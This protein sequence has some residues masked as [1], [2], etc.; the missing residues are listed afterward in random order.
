[1]N[2]QNLS[3][4][5]ENMA[6]ISLRQLIYDN[7]QK[8]G[9]TILGGSKLLLPAD[10]D[11]IRAAHKVSVNHILETKRE[12][13]SRFEDKFLEKYIINGNELDL[14]NIRPT[15]LSISNSHQN[16]L[17][18][19]IKL[20]WSVPV[21]SGY[22]RRL[23]YIVYDKGNDATIGIIGFADPVYGLKDRENL[24]GW[25][26][27]VKKHKLKNIMDA[28]VLGSVPPYSYILGGKLVASLV[29]SP[30]IR[31][32]FR[33]KYGGKRTRIS[34]EIF[35]GRLA[36]IT[37]ASALGKSS[38]YDRIRIPGGS[39]FIHAG[40]SKGSGEFQFYNGVYEEIF[41]LAHNSS[42]KFK[43]PKWGNGV[44]NRRTVIKTA[45]RMLG[46][47]PDLLYHSVKRELFVVPTG[48]HSFRFLKGE[49]KQIKYYYI[50]EWEIADYAI[51]R[52]VLSRAQRRK[53]YLDFRKESYSLLNYKR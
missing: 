6:V 40:W 39:E 28:F 31:K 36:A 51:G 26:P 50:K 11:I 52:W 33:K 19:W 35:D 53:E 21:S 14:H 30:T 38:V 10:K 25:T 20:H 13:I 8:A 34:N 16:D 29:M 23:R 49:T 22:G 43:N 44:R 27:E 3:L 42:L 41:K 4:S 46:M 7:L 24:I 9:F 48:V 2:N 5:F 47:S 12:F 32:D 17:F 45:L 18:N 37:T 15:L 1:M